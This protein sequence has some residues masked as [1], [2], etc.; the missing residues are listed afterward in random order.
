[1]P[2]FGHKNQPEPVI[3]E[4]QAYNEQPNRKRYL[5]SRRHRSTSP[6]GVPMNARNNNANGYA[7]DHNNTRSSTRSGG[8]FSRRRSHSSDDSMTHGST[9]SGSGHGMGFNSP[10]HGKHLNDP[11]IMAAR[12]KV[13]EAEEAERQAD[14]ALVEARASVRE[15]KEHVKNLE[16]EIEEE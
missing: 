12:Q 15:A 13:A 10:I 16:R 8:F 14:R 2:L 1:M 6:N 3:D 4:P 11:S 7:D 9:R 5:L